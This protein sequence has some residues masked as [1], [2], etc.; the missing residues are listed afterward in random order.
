MRTGRQAGELQGE[1]RQKCPDGICTQVY[2]EVTQ[3][4]GVAGRQAGRQVVVSRKQQVSTG[5]WSR[6]VLF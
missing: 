4:G 5:R 3:A 2:A 1:P 6:N